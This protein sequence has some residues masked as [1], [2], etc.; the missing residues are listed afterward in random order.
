MEGNTSC[1][2]VGFVWRWESIWE[3][4]CSPKDASEQLTIVTMT[5]VTSEYDSSICIIAHFYRLYSR[6][7][8]TLTSFRRHCRYQSRSFESQLSILTYGTRDL[9]LSLLWC[10][11]SS[12]E[13]IPNPGKSSKPIRSRP[14]GSMGVNPAKVSMTVI[15]ECEDIYI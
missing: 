1:T 14:Q 4:K 2:A 13:M 8:S 9:F 10:S 6:L 15:V 3:Q 12:I 7:A 5:R 11:K